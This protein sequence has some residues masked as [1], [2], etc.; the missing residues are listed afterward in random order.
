MFFEM[1]LGL[2][3]YCAGALI[4]KEAGCRVTDLLGRELAFDGPSS[5]AAASA[6][7]AEKPYLPEDLFGIRPVV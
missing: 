3:D 4:A 2:W 1:R 6:G 5:V 7:T